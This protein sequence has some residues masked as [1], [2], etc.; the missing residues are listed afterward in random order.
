MKQGGTLYLFQNS[1]YK[2]FHAL[3]HDK[4]GCNIP[5]VARG[6][7]LLCAEIEPQAV[8]ADL[9]TAVERVR[10]RGFC[11]L[12]ETECDQLKTAS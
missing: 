3:S 5:P 2:A 9:V 11:I 7:W 6:R 8:E 1:A 4:T 10:S 12:L